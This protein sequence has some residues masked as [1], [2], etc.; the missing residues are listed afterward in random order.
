MPR[1]FLA[2]SSGVMSSVMWTSNAFFSSLP[3][4]SYSF[5]M[6]SNTL[7]NSSAESLPCLPT[8]LLWFVSGVKWSMK[9]MTSL[10]NVLRI[11]SLWAREN[12]AKAVWKYEYTIMTFLISDL[13]FW[14]NTYCPIS[15]QSLTLSNNVFTRSLSNDIK[16]FCNILCFEFIIL[17]YFGHLTSSLN[18]LDCFFIQSLKIKVSKFIYEVLFAFIFLWNL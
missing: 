5:V 11:M 2:T 7:L 4:D 15:T 8:S 18:C 10:P 16:L 14:N 17:E 3:A 1:T 12:T 6:D 9:K 13:T